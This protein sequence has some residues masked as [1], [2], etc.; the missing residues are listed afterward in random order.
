M[1]HIAGAAPQDGEQLFAEVLADQ[2]IFLL[3]PTG[4]VSQWSEAAAGFTGHA[5]AEILGTPLAGLFTEED[6]A[7]GLPAATLEEAAR[8]ERHRLDGWCRR[9]DGS[10]RRA[11]I[12][13][14][15]LRDG[16]GGLAGFAMILRDPGAWGPLRDRMTEIERRFRLLVQGMTDCALYMLDVEGHIS[17]WNAGAER[18]KGFTEAEVLGTHFSRFYTAEDR[19]RDLPSRALARAVRTGRFEGEGWRVRRDGSRFWASVT[20]QPVHDDQGRLIGFAKLTRDITQRRRTEQ[21]LQESERR[22]RLLVESVTDYAIFM[23]D[24]DGRVSNWNAGAERIKGYAAAEILGQPYTCF[25]T[26]E[27]RAEGLPTRALV[28]AAGEGRFEAEGWRVRKDG[29]RFWASMVVN[30]VREQGR[31]VG[32]VKVTRDVTERRSAQVA[33]EEM[34]EQLAQS[35]RLE[36][37][38]QLTGGVAHDFNNLLQI[39]SVGLRLIE[40][41][42]PKEVLQA[43][44]II[45]SVRAAAARGAELTRQLLAFSRRLPMQSEAVDTIERVRE[46]ASLAAR[47]IRSD[48]RIEVELP[49][50]LW[51]VMVDPTQFELALL[52]VAIN[53]RDA[54]PQGGLLRFAAANRMLDDRKLGLEGRYVVVRISDTGTGIPKDLIDRVL[55]PF[56]TTKPVGKG[57]GLGLSQAYGFAKQSGG[58]LDIETELGRGTIVTFYLPACEGGAKPAAADAALAATPPAP[59]PLRVLVVEQDPSV[60]RLAAGLIEEAG[61]TAML[62]PDPD[63]ALRRLEEAPESVDLLFVNTLLPGGASGPV[64][65]EELRRRW[66]ALPVLLASGSAPAP[67]DATPLLAPVIRKPYG[68]AELARALAEAVRSVQSD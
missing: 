15:A 21:A 16:Q 52:N 35:Q 47:S 8:A 38:G 44:E 41:R 48:I 30:A 59:A 53:A 61:H 63:A 11:L 36:A 62:V 20:I 33:L 40:R 10:R 28:I 50:E 5:A 42:V 3:D 58:T 67:G 13:V 45:A 34:R 23:L 19:Q 64:R 37:I 56:F 2:A 60:G 27:D 55:E 25:F 46:A 54:M 39:I 9:S 51:A 14:Q 65:I 68:E 17:S 57:T 22:F 7:A 4:C 18:I 29:S 66:P 1:G 24:L 49:D 32:F 12:L 43:G 31:L 6:R 26:E